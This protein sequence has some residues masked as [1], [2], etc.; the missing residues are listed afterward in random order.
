MNEEIK[1]FALTRE[2]SETIIEVIDQSEK[3]VKPKKGEELKFY[4]NLWNIK[5]RLKK[6]EYE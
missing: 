5:N 2:E 3:L 4:G 6:L 1:R